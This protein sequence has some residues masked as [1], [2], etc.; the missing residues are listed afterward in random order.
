MAFEIRP[1]RPAEY[2]ALGNVTADVDAVAYPPIEEAREAVRHMHDV[3]ARVAG[4]E[5]T[6]IASGKTSGKVLGG[7]QVVEERALGKGPHRARVS[8]IISFHDG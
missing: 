1:V 7:V 2:E 3:E 8:R 6:F 5:T 4:S